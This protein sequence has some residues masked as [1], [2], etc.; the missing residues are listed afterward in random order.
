MAASVVIKVFLFILTS[1]G[2]VYISR[3]SLHAPLTHG[4]PR[5][6]AWEGILALF[7]VNV[8][9]WFHDP[10]SVNQ[11]F[12]WLLLIISIV[13]IIYGVWSLRVIGKPDS[14]REGEALLGIEKTTTL[15]TTGIYHYIR[16][17]FYSS[18][19]FLAWG[20]FLKNLSWPGTILVFVVSVC[21]ELT[22]VI[23]EGEDIGFFGP[24]YQE[25]MKETKKF[26]PFLY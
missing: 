16:H 12:S 21:L 11:V 7:L 15:V 2:L 19:L 25:Y 18:L 9:R 6:I 14:T 17:P 3:S 5:F 8:Q 26:I 13:M 22:A 1:I 4:F 20:I 24:K 10:F 23:E